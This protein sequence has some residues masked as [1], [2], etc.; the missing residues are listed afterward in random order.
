[1][2]KGFRDMQEK[3]RGQANPYEQ[4]STAPEPKSSVAGKGDYI[5]FEEVK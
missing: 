5:D 3:M 2:K 1:V 4:Q